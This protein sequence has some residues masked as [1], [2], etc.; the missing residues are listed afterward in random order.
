[1]FLIIKR[2]VSHAILLVCVIIFTL[3]CLIISA[4]SIMTSASSGSAYS[5]LI[6]IDEKTLYL[7]EDGEL[8]KKYPIA[9]GTKDMPSPIGSWRIVN[10][11]KW[12]KG[13]GGHWMGLN[14]PWGT[15]GIHGTKREDTIGRAASHG[16]IRM[17]NRDVKELYRIVPINTPVV[18]NN[19]PFGPFGTGFK[20]IHPGDRGADVYAVQERL[21]KLG[22]FNGYV[23]GIYGEDL[24][25]AVHKFQADHNLKVKNAIT[26]EDYEAMGFKEFE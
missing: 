1:M 18:I 21:K 16:C 13:F 20:E 4:Q 5:I 3:G 14:V 2:R 26:H 8:I 17:Y 22:Y 9:S 19:G 11:G 6:E 7:F 15:Y 24:K 23:S 12:S 25:V 10:K